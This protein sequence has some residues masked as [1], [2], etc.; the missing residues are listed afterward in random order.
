[1]QE[2][3]QPRVTHIMLRGNFRKLGE[4]VKPGVPA[5]LHPL[6][7]GAPA[8]RLRSG[9]MARGREQS[10]DGA[11]DHESHVGASLRHRNRRRPATTSAP[12]AN[13]RRTRNCSIGSP[14]SL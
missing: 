6:P 2:L 8:N 1:M 4:E 14:W 13:R 10:A 5:K 11:R 3:P 9:E 12:R 7:A